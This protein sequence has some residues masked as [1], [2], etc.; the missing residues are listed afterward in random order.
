MKGFEVTSVAG[1]GTLLSKG[2][3]NSPPPRAGGQHPGDILA[4]E[5]HQLRSV[6]SMEF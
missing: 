6:L 5:D 3:T 2:E 1:A 4:W